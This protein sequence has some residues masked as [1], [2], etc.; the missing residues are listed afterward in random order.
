MEQA[1]NLACSIFVYEVH[2]SEQPCFLS[3]F[4]AFFAKRLGTSQ[5]NRYCG[6]RPFCCSTR[7]RPKHIFAKGLEFGG[8][9]ALQGSVAAPKRR[10][11]T[12]SG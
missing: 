8:E 11:S 5:D 10:C 6:G 2:D 7:C 9:R 3:C 1:N 12:E 4:N